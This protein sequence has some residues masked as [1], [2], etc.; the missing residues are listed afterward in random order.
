MYQVSVQLGN[1]T[2]IHEAMKNVAR[3]HCHWI[4]SC[5][6]PLIVSVIS[7][8]RNAL[9]S[10]KKRSDGIEGN[11]RTKLYIQKKGLWGNERLCMLVWKMCLVR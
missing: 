1:T 4:R 10:S 6:N 9:T 5:M 3:K 7:S 8:S 2:L 11:L